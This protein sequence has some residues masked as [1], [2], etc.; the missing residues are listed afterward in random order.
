MEPKAIAPQ[1][2]RVGDRVRAEYH[3]GAVIEDTITQVGTFIWGTVS[4]FSRQPNGVDRYP[5]LVLLDRPEPPREV[6]SRWR[7]PE[8]GAEYVRTD[9]TQYRYVRYR[10]GN[11]PG[12]VVELWSMCDGS[13]IIA[14]LVPLDGD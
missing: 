14:R 5:R 4:S 3:A 11:P 10:M 1:D 2:I 6:G 13:D 9:D 8:T 7:D 12:G